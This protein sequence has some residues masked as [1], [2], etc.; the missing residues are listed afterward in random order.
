MG[1][2]VFASSN[3]HKFDEARQILSSAGVG[4]RFRHCDIDELQTTDASRLIHQKCLDAYGRIARPLIVEHTTL[5][6]DTYG[7]FPAGLTSV[8]LKNVG[9][10]GATDLLGRPGKNRAKATT[11]VAFTDG[12]TISLFSGSMSGEI[13]ATPAV[14]DTNW[15]KFGWN[16][17]FK[18][19]GF[20]KSLAEIGPT[21]KNT[22][23]MRKIALDKLVAGGVLPT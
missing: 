4:L 21:R 1:D 20:T 11:T 13:L 19:D 5:H 22:F 23:S 18:P 3:Q 6:S 12:K 14:T 9:L 16:P 2:L 17:I 10:A 8:F 7:G 15:K